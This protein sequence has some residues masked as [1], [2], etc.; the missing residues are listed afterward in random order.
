MKPS[1]DSS[2]ARW[3][4]QIRDAQ[5]ARRQLL[6]CVVVSGCWCI[7]ASN[8]W[9]WSRAKPWGEADNKV[10]GAA[11][12]VLSIDG[13]GVT[14]SIQLMKWLWKEACNCDWFCR[15]SYQVSILTVL[16]QQDLRMPGLSAKYWLSQLGMWSPGKNM[17]TLWLGKLSSAHQPWNWIHWYIGMMGR[18]MIT[19]VQTP[20]MYIYICMY[21]IY[22][23]IEYF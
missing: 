16:H 6:R 17:L 13:A 2:V 12:V 23:Y 10:F 21:I 5:Q 9:T 1:T 19:Y 3:Q 15:E 4:S 11:W 7:V 20:Y 22:I 14:R 18:R 8:L